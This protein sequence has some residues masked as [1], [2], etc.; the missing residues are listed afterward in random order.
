MDLSYS[1][2]ND[3]ENV[4]NLGT[5]IMEKMKQITSDFKIGKSYIIGLL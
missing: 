2:K 5:V 4:K 3:L 1:M